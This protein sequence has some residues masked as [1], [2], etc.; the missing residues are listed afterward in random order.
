M[1]PGVVVVISL[2][3]FMKKSSL[4]LVQ[5]VTL[6][7]GLLLEELVAPTEATAHSKQ[8]LGQAIHLPL[9]NT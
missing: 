6:R 2:N 9:L 5:V 7:G 1:L 8:S 4:H 3:P